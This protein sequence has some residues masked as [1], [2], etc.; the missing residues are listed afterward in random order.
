MWFQDIFEK[1]EALLDNSKL[2]DDFAAFKNEIRSTTRTTNRSD[3]QTTTV[4]PMQM[5]L[6][7]HQSV[8]RPRPLTH[9]AEISAELITCHR[10]GQ[11]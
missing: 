3:T 11:S 10:V 9:P 2:L 8:A 1:A 7:V 4:M 6:V 5:L